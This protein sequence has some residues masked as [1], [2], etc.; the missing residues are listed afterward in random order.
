[1]QDSEDKN[2][3]NKDN[4]DECEKPALLLPLKSGRQQGRCTAYRPPNRKAK[5]Q[6]KQQKVRK[7]KPK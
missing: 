1:M 4:E 3:V 2:T 7:N 6:E 5:I